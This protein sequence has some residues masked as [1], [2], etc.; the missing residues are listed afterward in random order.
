MPV[1]IN[2]A[3]IL[4]KDE[5]SR[6]HFT[7]EGTIL[8]HS[9]PDYHPAAHCNARA[10][11]VRRYRRTGGPL[12]RRRLWEALHKSQRNVRL[13][14][15]G[16]HSLLFRPEGFAT[17][18]QSLPLIKVWK[19][20]VFST[21]CYT[22]YHCQARH[23]SAGRKKFSIASGR[24]CYNVNEDIRPSRRYPAKITVRPANV[25]ISVAVRP[26]GRCCF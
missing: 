5:C 4:H 14:A 21:I 15:C 24:I 13:S 7:W 26:K 3:P 16:P 6:F 11:C 18:S 8:P 25:D 2:K 22:V 19:Y 1:K 17:L 23:A 10:I 20:F 12:C 9:V